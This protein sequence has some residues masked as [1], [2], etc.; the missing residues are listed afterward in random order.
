MLK[1][2]DKKQ[3]EKRL[4]EVV[5]SIGI[6]ESSHPDH[7]A[8]FHLRSERKWMEQRLKKT[9]WYNLSWRIKAARGAFLMSTIGIR[10]WFY[11][12]VYNNTANRVMFFLTIIGL[13]TLL[14][15]YQ[16]RVL[17]HWDLFPDS[18]SPIDEWIL[19]K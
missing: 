7:P 8:L 5:S 19:G 13:A 2:A 10:I 14:I 17:F 9:F 16:G 11:T 6:L 3:L 4:E 1:N 12:K 15:L 18:D